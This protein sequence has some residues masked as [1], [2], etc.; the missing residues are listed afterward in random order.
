MSEGRDHHIGP[1]I[2][3]FLAERG[4]TVSLEAIRLWCIKFGAKYA[5][6][7]KRKHRGCGDTLFIDE[8]FLQTKRDGAA[9]TCFLKR[10]L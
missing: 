9:A 1:F 4:I 6:R 10:L 3:D 7:L 2:G 5:R 8:V